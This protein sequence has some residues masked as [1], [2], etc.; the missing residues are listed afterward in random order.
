VFDEDRN[1][2]ALSPALLAE[3]KRETERFNVCDEKL[4]PGR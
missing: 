3:I 1:G 2:A 4:A